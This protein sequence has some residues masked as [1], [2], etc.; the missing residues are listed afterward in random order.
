MK[1]ETKFDIG[2]TAWMMYHSQVIEVE[3]LKLFISSHEQGEYKY[4]VPKIDYTVRY[5]QADDN[6]HNIPESELFKTK[7]ELLDSL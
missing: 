5:K 6:W 4:I 3:I 2:D 7:Q 1:L